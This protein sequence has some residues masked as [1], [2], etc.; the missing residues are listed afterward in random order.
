MVWI[1]PESVLF[2]IVNSSLNPIANPSME[3]D[4]FPNDRN[5]GWK[6]NISADL[7]NHIFTFS[8]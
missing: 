5:S 4:R 2:T 8:N 7:S 6:K 1:R 3:T